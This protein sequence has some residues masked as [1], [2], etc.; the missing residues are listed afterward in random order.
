[1]DSFVNDSNTR[2][3]HSWFGSN[4]P[5]VMQRSAGQLLDGWHLHSSGEV[6]YLSRIGGLCGPVARQ[7]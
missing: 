3:W 1:M 2:L 5:Y 6:E 7:L 4:I